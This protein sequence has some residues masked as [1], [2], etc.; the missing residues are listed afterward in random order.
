VLVTI[1]GHTYRSPVAVYV[2]WIEEAKHP[3]TRSRRI[4]KPV[5]MLRGGQSRL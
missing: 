2:D 5:A 3:E 1:R 4:G